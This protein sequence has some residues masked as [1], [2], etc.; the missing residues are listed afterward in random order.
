MN[1]GDD[2]ASSSYVAY[3]IDGASQGNHYVKDLEAGATETTTFTWFTQP[4]SHTV[5]V[6]TDIE[7]QILESDEDNNG[8]VFILPAPD[9]IIEQLTWSP[10]QPSQDDTVTFS[11]TIK[12]QGLGRA[13][14]PGVYYDIDET[15]ADYLG[16]KDLE[17]GDTATATFTWSAQ[18]GP[19]T[20]KAVVDELNQL[21]ENDEANNEQTATFEVSPPPAADNTSAP[22][23]SA[24]AN[25]SGQPEPNDG[26]NE[27]DGQ[28]PLQD[29][30]PE[31]PENPPPVQAAGKGIWQGW[32]LVLGGA[33][34]G[35]T[36]IAALLRLRRK[37]H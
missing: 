3:E 12:N 33:A 10:A 11:I 35:C 34:V 8:R 23:P 15:S 28:I 21:L 9:L 20:I 25:T 14:A 36:V 4:G 16:V 26:I 5:K 1:Q 37:S 27:P 24:S 32:W 31:L 22:A 17:A 7:N 6:I 2:G 18:A 19:H 30:D 13:S 29:A